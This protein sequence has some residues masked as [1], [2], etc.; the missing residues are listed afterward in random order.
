MLKYFLYFYTLPL[1][2]SLTAK[3][4][5]TLFVAVFL[6]YIS[7]Y[8]LT[9]FL[10]NMI[11]TVLADENTSSLI[12]TKSNN[13]KSQEE[14]QSFYTKISNFWSGYKW[15]IIAGVTIGIGLLVFNLKGPNGDDSP[16]PSPSPSPTPALIQ[17]NIPTTIVQNLPTSTPVPIQHVSPEVFNQSLR[18]FRN[19]DILADPGNL[20]SLDRKNMLS[21]L[22]D[23]IPTLSSE[24]K[25]NYLSVVIY[26]L[27][28]NTYEIPVKEL[29]N[30]AH[31]K[32][33]FNIL[34][35]SGYTYETN[36]WN[37]LVIKIADVIQDKYQNKPI[38]REVFNCVDPDLIIRNFEENY[39]NLRESMIKDLIQMDNDFKNNGAIMLK[40]LEDR[41]RR[42]DDFEPRDQD[43]EK[44]LEYYRQLF[45]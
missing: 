1:L 17:E 4:L 22:K 26:N 25:A 45:R 43:K 6:S 19:L 18:N 36:E 32:E 28:I 5:L 24:A 12:T 30:G 37:E 11:P 21:M 41:L 14:V 29:N 10:L 13:D 2:L 7:L 20:W 27:I 15:Y 3:R 16:S 33:I 9:F 42:C 23:L 34:K 44:S 39:R 35:A 31:I 40:D 38:A 8:L